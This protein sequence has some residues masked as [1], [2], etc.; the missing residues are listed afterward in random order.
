MGPLLATMA[1]KSYSPAMPSL[2]VARRRCPPRHLIFATLIII[3][4]CDL[5]ERRTCARP[6]PIILQFSAVRQ[7]PL[8]HKARGVRWKMAFDNFAGLDRDVG[9]MTAIGRKEMRRRVIDEI[10]PD[11][12]AVE[13]SDRRHELPSPSSCARLTR[14]ST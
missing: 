9:F 14:E 5:A 10:H 7:C 12:D 2:N 8:L 1:E 11:G 6:P 13:V 4:A 3:E